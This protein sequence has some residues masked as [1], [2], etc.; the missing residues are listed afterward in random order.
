MA[1]KLEHRQSAMIMGAAISLAAVAVAID[2]TRHPLPKPQAA[3]VQP[4]TAGETPCGLEAPCGMGSESPCGMGE[5][6]CG[7]EGSPCDL[8]PC[9]LDESAPP[10]GLGDESPCG[11]G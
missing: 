8:A 9:S 5:S 1:K 4:Q 6:P 3:V 11:L 2:T 10:C 7:L